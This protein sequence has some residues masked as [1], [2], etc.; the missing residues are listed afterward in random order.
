MLQ[1]GF[2]RADITPPA[3]VRLIGY[4]VERVSNGFLDPLEINCIALREGEKTALLLT[5]DNLGI[6]RPYILLARAEIARAVGVDPRG[7]FIHSTHTHT[8]PKLALNDPEESECELSHAR[9]V[10]TKFGEAAAAAIADLCPARV[11]FAASRAESIGYNRRYLM[12][13]GTVKTNPGLYNP[14]VVRSIGFLDESVYVLRFEREDGR[15]IAIANYAN[16]PDTIGGTQISGDWPALARR[17]FE[18]A[19]ENSRLVVLNGCQ[20]DIN[21]VNAKPFSGYMNGMTVDFDGVPRGYAHATHMGNVLAG[22]AMAVYEKVTYLDSAPLSFE[23]R[24]IEIPQNKPTAAEM[25]EARHIMEYHLT[26]R[27]DLLPYKDMMLTTMVADAARK[28]QLENAPETRS[29]VISLIKLGEIAI[30]GLPGEPFAA[31]GAG[32]RSTPG[33]RMIL[34][35][36]NTN[37]KEGYFPMQDSYDEGGYEAKTSPFRAGSA[38]L[39]IEKSIALLSEML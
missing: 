20:G 37:A 28:L 9:S 27:D 5:V 25:P 14:D 3:G 8:G 22:A 32:I 21:H 30:L 19:V 6:M 31:V 24:Q 11:G 26:G 39:L 23:E 15:S 13:D 34:T 38:E 36:C 4:F 29:T 7:I 17:T 35:S 16:H 12:K 10:L 18:R 33:Y 1:V 2:S